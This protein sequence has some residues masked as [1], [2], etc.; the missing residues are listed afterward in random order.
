MNGTLF[1]IARF[2]PPSTTGGVLENGQYGIE[3]YK[4]PQDALLTGASPWQQL[5]N[6][7]TNA[8]GFEANFLAGFVRDSYGNINVASYPTIQMYTSISYPPPNWD[9]T[10]A[11]AGASAVPPNLDPDAY[12]VGADASATI[13][14]NR[15]FNGSVHEVTTGWV[16]PSG[17]FQLQKASRPSLCESAARSDRAV[18][19]LQ[20]STERLLCFARCRLRRSADSRARKATDTR[21]RFPDS[22]W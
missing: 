7:D 16:S 13:P 1:S 6:M 22:T 8:T 18:L 10:P 4:I 2:G 11:E 17:K 15:Y 12:G 5:V 20:G 21:N 9:A 3:L 19:W 14:F